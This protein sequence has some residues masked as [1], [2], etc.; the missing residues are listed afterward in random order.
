MLYV[1]PRYPELSQTFVQAEVR[2]VGQQ[3]T[4]VSVAAW[5]AS[6][7]DPRTP[8]LRPVR[9]GPRAV[10]RCAV[11]VR[12]LGCSASP[13]DAVL[14]TIRAAS[15]LGPVRSAAPDLVHAHFASRPTHVAAVLAAALG[16]PLTAV[17]HARDYRVG[18]PSR[19]LKARLAR[20]ARVFAISED[21]RAELTARSGHADIGLLRASWSVPEGTRRADREPVDG[22]PLRVVTVARLVPKK[23]L[24]VAIRAVAR[25]LRAGVPVDY[26]IVGAGPEHDRL[27]ALVRELDVGAHVHLTGPA[28][29]ADATAEVARADV[30]IMLCRRTVDGDADGIPV[31]LMEA[32]ALEVPI[33]STT[34]GGIAELVEDGRTGILVPPDDIPA[35]ADALT[36]LLDRPDLR[37]SLAE[38]AGHRVRAE[39]DPRHQAELLVA[40][41]RR[42]VARP[43]VLELDGVRRP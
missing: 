23:G 8:V 32:A 6:D 25:C 40:E 4:K 26:R 39:F 14:T 41:W 10:F 28:A 22:S 37:R 13:A 18:L 33:L 2:Q 24:D 15:L 9:P 42:L 12:R 20:A 16:I 7:P 21:A 43:A 3:G 17:F 29:H 34:V 1:V 27:A 30:A 11:L 38:A 35:A 36:R 19:A 5:H 31:S